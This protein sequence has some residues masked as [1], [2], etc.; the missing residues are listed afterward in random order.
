MPRRNSLHEIQG[1]ADLNRLGEVVVDKRQQQ[2]ATKKRNRRNRHV[3]KQFI[4]HALAHRAPGLQDDDDTAS[5]GTDLDAD[6]SPPAAAL[7]V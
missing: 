5:P 1:L 2:R 4:R 3:E 6:E 7:R